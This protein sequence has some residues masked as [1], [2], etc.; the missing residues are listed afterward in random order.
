MSIASNLACASVC[1]R[2]FFCAFSFSDSMQ[3]LALGT[4]SGNV[5]L[6][7]PIDSL[8]DVG[9]GPF[10]LLARRGRLSDWS[11]VRALARPQDRPDLCARYKRFH[12]PPNRPKKCCGGPLDHGLLCLR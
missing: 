2:S 8:D 5:Q 7:E 4:S 1:S 11:R 10:V 6:N 3:A 12:T 9:L